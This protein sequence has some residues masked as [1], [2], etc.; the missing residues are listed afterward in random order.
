MLFR[1]E[2]EENRNCFVYCEFTSDGE[3][4]ITERLKTIIEDNLGLH[5]QVE[6]LKASSPSAIDRMKWIREKAA[7]GIKVFITNPRLVETGLDFIFKHNKM[8][9]NYPTIIFYQVGYNLFTAW[10]ASARHRRLIQTR[11]CRTYYM[12]YEETLQG[13]ALETLANKKAA[14]AALQ[15]T[16][17][18]EGLIAMANSIDPKVLLA[19]ALMNGSQSSDMSK[20]FD[21]INERKEIELSEEEKAIIDNITKSFSEEI[22]NN[23]DSKGIQLTLGDFSDE[24][25]KYL[26]FS[27]IEAASGSGRT[28]V[29]EGQ[30]TL[31]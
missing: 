12:F 17:S 14:T 7:S 24:F 27:M 18:E 16:F 25:F 30:L 31:F 5:G 13:V 20:L 1:S 22:Q 11:E 26:N 28:K 23:A 6:I 2:L 10:Q 9:Y 21:K 15:G 8:V 29:L 4:N 19:N 3:K